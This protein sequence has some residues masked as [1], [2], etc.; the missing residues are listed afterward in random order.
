MRIILSF[1]LFLLAFR[2]YPQNENTAQ[3]WT[4]FNQAQYGIQFA[5]EIEMNNAF[6]TISEV[7]LIKLKK[8]YNESFFQNPEAVENS[9]W[10]DEDK[11]INFKF[12][13]D[14]KY[15]LI[16]PPLK[17]NSF[18]KIKITYYDPENI[19]SI[20]RMIHS[21][22]NDNW[23]NEKKEWMKK[24]DALNNRSKPKLL[25]YQVQAK[26]FIDYRNLL[27]QYDLNSLSED[28]KGALIN[29][30]KRIFENLN[31][32]NIKIRSGL[33]F[34]QAIIE[35]AK[36]VKN[37]GESTP[38][39]EDLIVFEQ[40]YFRC[41]DYVAIY[42]FY[43][44]YLKQ[45]LNTTPFDAKNYVQKFKESVDLERAKFNDKDLPNYLYILGRETENKEPPYYSTFP[46]NF[47][48]GY[49]NAIVPDFGFIVYSNFSGT[50][51]GGSPFV[52]VNVS[53]SPSNKNVPMQLSNLTF[54]QKL[55][56][57]TGILLNSV[58]ENGKRQDLFS[59][60]S[61]L[62]GLSY[63]FLNH[64]Y[65]ITAGTIVY[66]QIDPIDSQKSLALAP[67]LGLSIDIEIKKWLEGIFPDLKN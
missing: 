65:R 31:F 40:Q 46:S 11:V 30:T 22:G 6:V 3:V 49:K 37:T 24:V 50:F 2:S 27:S 28:D 61:L 43:D 54:A 53:L 5:N 48:E 58:K 66:N 67:Y 20:I 19:I 41:I 60:T 36:Y 45:F 8:A 59:N 16:F 4:T 44:N 18:Y 32:N 15:K 29:Q 38:T 56:I 63:K 14:R 17:P 1:I 42:G 7:K 9:W 34:E 33:T 64:A 13:S 57:H 47:T 35:Y 23:Y 51:E 62:V 26:D 12:L 55:A 10:E 25:T 39:D 21:E 52:G